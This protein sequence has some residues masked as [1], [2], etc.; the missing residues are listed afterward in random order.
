M[1]CL[2]LVV[3]SDWACAVMKGVSTQSRIG[4][5]A[6][7]KKE[8]FYHSEREL[9]GYLHSLHFLFYHGYM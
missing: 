7:R 6:G 4:D 5:E 9:L 8:N 2:E 3:P 1:F